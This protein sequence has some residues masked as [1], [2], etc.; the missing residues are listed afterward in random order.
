[1]F[2]GKNTLLPDGKVCQAFHQSTG[3]RNMQNPEMK[4]RVCCDEAKM[5]YKQMHEPVFSGHMPPLL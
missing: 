3:D 4:T 1:M 2:T 5:T